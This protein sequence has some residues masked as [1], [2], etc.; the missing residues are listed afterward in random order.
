MMRLVRWGE[1][2]AFIN[3]ID[4]QRL[5]NLRL[6]KMPNAYFGHHGNGH[7][8]DNFFDLGWV[9]HACHATLGANIGWTRSSA[10]TATA[11]ASSAILAWSAV[12][13]SMM[14]PPLSISAKPVFNLNSVS[15]MSDASC[16]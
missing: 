6:G 8:L 16:D 3:I 12:V 9:G 5:Q 10:I 15:A 11:P 14:T 7:S 2:F 4:P 13:T 1:H